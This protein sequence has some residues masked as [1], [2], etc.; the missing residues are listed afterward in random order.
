MPPVFRGN[1]DGF[2]PILYLPSPGRFS[3]GVPIESRRIERY[4]PVRKL[5]RIFEGWHGRRIQ[6]Q[7][8][9]A[10]DPL[11]T[12]EDWNLFRASLQIHGVHI[13][14]ILY[15]ASGSNS[16]RPE[17][18]VFAVHKAPQSRLSQVDSEV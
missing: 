3:R 15:G 1:S 9:T 10:D 14:E 17:R 11:S 16:D 8:T 7:G 5:L 6:M 2:R 12:A 4:R 18:G 13:G